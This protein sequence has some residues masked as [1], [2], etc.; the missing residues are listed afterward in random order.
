MHAIRFTVQTAYGLYA[1]ILFIVMVTITALMC[2]VVPGLQRRRGV[3]RAMSRAWLQFIGMPVK[4]IAEENLPDGQC[5]VVSNHASYLDGIVFTA[6][7][8]ARFG[9]VIKREMANVPLF[10]AF[11][12][13]LGA[14]FV[15]RYEAKKSAADARRVL[16]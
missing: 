6:A 7:L 13:R 10:G 1:S 9:F 11:L 4:V 8:P 15:E 3:A 16:R 14:M 12:T 5:V 2:L